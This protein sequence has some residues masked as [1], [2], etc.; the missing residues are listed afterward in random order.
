MY[1]GES[2]E[3]RSQDKKGD[4]SVSRVLYTIYRALSSISMWRYRH[5]LRSLPVVKT[6]QVP[7]HCSTLLQMRFTVP[8]P[9][10]DMRWALT[11]PFHPY[12]AP[13]GARR[14]AFCCTICHGFPCPGVTRHHSWWSPDFPLSTNADSDNT[15]RHPKTSFN[16]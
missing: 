7:S 12:P 6:V 1:K 15:T 3:K 16:T 8:Y 2:P 9:L 10:P 5:I 4:G 14:F 11:P 13:E